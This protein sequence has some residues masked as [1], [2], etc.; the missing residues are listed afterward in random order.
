MTQ[1]VEFNF[2]PCFQNPSGPQTWTG[3]HQTMT[4]LWCRVSSLHHPTILCF[5][6]WVLTSNMNSYHRQTSAISLCNKT[7]PIM[8]VCPAM[9][10]MILSSLFCNIC[11]VS[12]ILLTVLSLTSTERTHE[13]RTKQ[14]AADIFQCLL[15]PLFYPPSSSGNRFKIFSNSQYIFL[16]PSWVN[17]L[18]HTRER[19]RVLQQFSFVNISPGA[20]HYREAG[21]AF[22]AKNSLLFY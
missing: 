21:V 20:L 15:S 10:S 7:H 17:I 4:D 16:P 19:T 18:S 2:H 11:N 9:L 22:N 8:L 3:W 5:P 6:R 12:A 13:I 1:N 14:R